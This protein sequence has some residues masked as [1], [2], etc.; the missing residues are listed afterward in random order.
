MNLAARIHGLTGDL[1]HLIVTT[2]AVQKQAPGHAW[3][4]R[5]RHSLKGIADPVEVFVL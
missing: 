3:K 2:E 5:G 4:A 1:G